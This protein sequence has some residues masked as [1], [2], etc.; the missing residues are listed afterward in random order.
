MRRVLLDGDRAVGVVYLDEEDVEYRLTARRE[1]VLSAGAVHSPHLLQL[2]GI[3]DADVLRAAGIEPRVDLPGVGRH[4]QDHLSV[5]VIRFT[6]DPITL[7]NAEKPVELLKFL[8]RRRG[9]LTSNVG[10]GVAFIRSD[11]GVEHP[12]LELI[13]APGPFID[14][15]QGVPPGHGITLGVVLLQPGSSGTIAPRSA[16]PADPPLIDAAY[17]TDPADLRAAGHRRPP[18][19][20]PVRHQGAEPARHAADDARPRARTTSRSTSGSTPRPSTTRAAR[21]GWA[22]GPTT[23]STPSCGCAASQALRVVDASVM[24]AIIRGH[25]HAPTVMIAERAS[26]LLLG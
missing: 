13:F 11:P 24:P 3:G 5:P 25:T 9:M 2:S 23:S 16:D 15:G 7:V 6:R 26:D 4:L 22:P 1:V 10:E 19:A 14:H 21:A 17:L 12:D 8:V 18:R 20:G